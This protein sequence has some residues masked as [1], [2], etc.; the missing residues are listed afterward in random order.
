MSSKR[1][2]RKDLICD[3]IRQGK[4]KNQGQLIKQL[5]NRGLS[6]TQ[7]TISRDMADLKLEK[8]NRG[9]YCLQQDLVL[10]KLVASVVKEVKSA[11]NQVI[12]LTTP[13]SAQGVAAAIDGAALKNVL[14]CV[15]GD[16]TILVICEDENSAKFIKDKVMTLIN[17][18]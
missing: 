1:N 12:I 8:N 7:A 9:F 11:L 10:S 18:R 17:N 2:M 15:A 3:I 13:G 5:Q 6:V 4:I 14:G 16:D